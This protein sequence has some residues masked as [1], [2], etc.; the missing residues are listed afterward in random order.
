MNVM[1]LLTPRR[2]W[3]GVGGG[4]AAV[5]HFGHADGRE[6]ASLQTR[7]GQKKRREDVGEGGG[8]GTEAHEYYNSREFHFIYHRHFTE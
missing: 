7:K 1:L 5:C 6:R 2:G 4:G 8:D 3:V